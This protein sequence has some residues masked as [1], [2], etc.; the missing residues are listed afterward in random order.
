M[1]GPVSDGKS[2]RTA[3]GAIRRV[4]ARCVETASSVRPRRR[5]SFWFSWTKARMT[6]WSTLVLSLRRALS[7]RSR[8]SLIAD[9]PGGFKALAA[10]CSNT[11]PAA[12][13]SPTCL[14]L[15]REHPDSVRS[16]RH[17]Y[18]DRILI[19]GQNATPSQCSTATPGTT[20]D[21]R[22]HQ[23]REQRPPNYDPASAIP[24]TDPIHRHRV[25]GGV[26]DESPPSRLTAYQDRM[27]GFRHG[28]GGMSVTCLS[29]IPPAR[30]RT[31]TSCWRRVRTHGWCG[32]P[33]HRP[34]SPLTRRGGP[35]W[36]RLAWDV[37]P[38]ASVVRV[39]L[40]P[41]LAPHMLVACA[42]DGDLVLV[43]LASAPQVTVAVR[44]RWGGGGRTPRPTSMPGGATTHPFHARV[45]R[46]ASTIRLRR[47]S[48]TLLA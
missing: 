13:K 9:K 10:F 5:S 24:I 4:G 41:E 40:S 26:V 34:S 29:T 1:I 19:Y 31:A 30:R 39:M 20:T 32:W 6:E 33:C 14:Q 8:A 23:G 42:P 35:C 16:V 15:H 18:T 3:Y 21:H 38:V 37:A 27:P 36:H 11:T 45:T 48:W 12:E 25:L 44:R 47:S 17:E 22:P 46:P 43:T 2:N 28:T 7:C